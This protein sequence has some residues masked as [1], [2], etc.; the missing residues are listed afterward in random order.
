MSSLNYE[1]VEKSRFDKTKYKDENCVY[2]LHSTRA[3][4][5]KIRLGQSLCIELLGDEITTIEFKSKDITDALTS[6]SKAETLT[7]LGEQKILQQ[8]L[9][10]NLSHKAKT[11]MLTPNLK[12][13]L[14]GQFEAT[15][16]RLVN[17]ISLPSLV[18]QNV[19]RYKNYM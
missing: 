3:E 12:D 18:R 8:N 16:K 17:E 9:K 11:C 10:Y 4:L 7:A 19:P 6:T 5:V 13:D 15:K 2:E 14:V 1:L